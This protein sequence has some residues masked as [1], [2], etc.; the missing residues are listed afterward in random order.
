MKLYKGELYALTN[1][2]ENWFAFDVRYTHKR[3]GK[4]YFEST[5]YYWRYIVDCE[6]MEVSRQDLDTKEIINLNIT[7]KII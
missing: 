1:K 3:N 4:L 2:K 5:V 6:T 7:V